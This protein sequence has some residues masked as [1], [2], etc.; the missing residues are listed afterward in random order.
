MSTE[1]DVPLYAGLSSVASNLTLY[2]VQQKAAYVC[3]LGNITAIFA[4]G[5][6]VS[7]ECLKGLAVCPARRV[8]R[9]S[10]RRTFVDL[11][12]RTGNRIQGTFSLSGLE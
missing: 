10:Y 9:H 3:V 4:D 8:V 6:R 1:P 11:L 2:S 12:F 7:W 5:K